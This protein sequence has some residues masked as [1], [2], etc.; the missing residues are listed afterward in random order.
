MARG[1]PPAKRIVRM[2]TGPKTVSVGGAAP[3]S[4]SHK[5]L[6]RVKHFKPHKAAAK[7]GK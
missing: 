2:S 4:T 6:G 1:D 7:K 3:K 5:T